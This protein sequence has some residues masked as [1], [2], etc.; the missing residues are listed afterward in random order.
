[1]WRDGYDVHIKETS[2]LH[3][4]RI[5]S[6]DA[7]V[8]RRIALEFFHQEEQLAPSNEPPLAIQK[9]RQSQNKVW[10]SAP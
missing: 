7:S 2:A 4:A 5:S 8:V 9:Q 3:T 6:A 10:L 1:M